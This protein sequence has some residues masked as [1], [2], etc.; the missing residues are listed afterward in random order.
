MK[1]HYF[2]NNLFNLDVESKVWNI[3]QI[4]DAIRLDFLN[5]YLFILDGQ[6]RFNDFQVIL[7]VLFLW[8]LLD[9]VI[10]NLMLSCLFYEFVVL[11]MVLNLYF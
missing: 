6:L 7:V 2:N 1:D 5:L 3:Y 10:F 8:L 9:I 4:T 11:F